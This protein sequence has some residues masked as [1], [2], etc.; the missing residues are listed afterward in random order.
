M[1]K[2]LHLLT[3]ALLFGSLGIAQ[4]KVV[5]RDKLVALSLISPCQDG[6]T[7][8]AIVTGHRLRPNGFDLSKFVGVPVEVTGTTGAITCKFVTVTG[9]SVIKFDQRSVPSKT[10]TTVKVEFYGT[11]NAVY[12]LYAGALA[13]NEFFLPS[14]LGPIHLTPAAVVYLGTHSPSS[15][16]KPYLTLTATLTPALIGVNFYDQAVAVT[17]T[18][19]DMTNVD[20]FKF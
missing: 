20:A 15:S 11:A 4:V 12:V 18:G 16:T 6:A 1:V 3:A 7:H 19:G 9:I 10:A 2:S 13:A 14:I 8:A 5:L 17:G